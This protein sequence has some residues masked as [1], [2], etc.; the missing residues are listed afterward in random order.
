MIDVKH[1]W[2]LELGGY[3]YFLCLRW[4]KTHKRALLGK[5]MLGIMGMPVTKN[6]AEW[7]GQTLPADIS[8]L[9]NRAQAIRFYPGTSQ[10]ENTSFVCRQPWLEMA[11][12]F[13]AL[14]S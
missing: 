5:E 6:M 7:I 3:C 11:W 8:M 2:Y 10:V 4:S 9:T 12:M 14:G 13:H 1:T